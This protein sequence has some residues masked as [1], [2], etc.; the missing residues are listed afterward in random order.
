MGL[1]R[2]KSLG[3]TKVVPL[4]RYQHEQLYLGEN[5]LAMREHCYMKGRLP[6]SFGLLKG[7]DG[8]FDPQ[9]NSSL[10]YVKTFN[11]SSS[12]KI[13]GA[14]GNTGHNYGKYKG[15]RIP[16]TGRRTDENFRCTEKLALLVPRR[17]DLL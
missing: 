5:F 15:P 9:S 14:G 10:D 17:S 4:N 3:I 8:P 2:C 6:M 11:I 7:P 16:F 1:D 13:Q 12:S